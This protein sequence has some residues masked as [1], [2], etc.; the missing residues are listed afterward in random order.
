MVSLRCR[1]IVPQDD[2]DAQRAS[3]R[4]GRAKC[5]GN[6]ETMKREAIHAIVPGAE[7]DASAPSAEL[8]IHVAERADKVPKSAV[9]NAGKHRGL[10]LPS[11][12]S[13]QS[14]PR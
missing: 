5:G 13:L 1:C 10:T 7:E 12:P 4:E 8:G 3:T 14:R 6:A 2:R 9:V 11:L